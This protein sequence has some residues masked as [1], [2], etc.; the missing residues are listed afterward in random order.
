MITRTI[1]AIERV[2]FINIYEP[3]RSL[4]TIHRSASSLD[5]RCCRRR[6]RRC[7]GEKL[8]LTKGQVTLILKMYED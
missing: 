4:V 5:V 8:M 1:R 7:H 3:N 2:C 6:L